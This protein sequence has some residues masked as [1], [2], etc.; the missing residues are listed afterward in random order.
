MRIILLAACLSCTTLATLKSAW[1]QGDP[2]RPASAQ[3]QGNANVE[4]ELKAVEL[5]LANLTIHGDW[6]EYEKYLAADYTRIKADG[7]LESKGE[8]MSDFRKGPR[9]IIVI[10]PED[11]RVRFYGEAAVMVGHVTTSVRESG[12]VNTR[13]ERF[14]ELFVKQGGQWSLAAEQETGMGK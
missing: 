1:A 12:R 13:N 5:K 4:E 14:T 6:D 10:E 7:K 2:A 8:V 11:L 9:K 3:A